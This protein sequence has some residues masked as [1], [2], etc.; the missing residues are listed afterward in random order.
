[1]SEAQVTTEPKVEIKARVWRIAWDR[2]PKHFPDRVWLWLGKRR[3]LFT[4]RWENL[5]VIASSEMG[6]ASA[7]F[8]PRS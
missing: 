3:I 2:K 5:G 4:G 1:M 7:E 8:T 6:T